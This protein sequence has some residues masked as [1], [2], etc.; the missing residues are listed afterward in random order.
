[1]TRLSKSDLALAANKALKDQQRRQWLLDFNGIVWHYERGY[2]AMLEI[3][4]TTPSD[5][6]PEGFKYCFTFHEPGIN[7]KAGKRIY[8][9]DNAHSPDNGPVY[10]HEH[11][12]TWTSEL[13][14]N[15]P[16]ES[17]PSRYEDASIFTAFEKFPKEV[18]RIMERLE[19]SCAPINQSR[20]PEKITGDNAGGENQDRGVISK[21]SKKGEKK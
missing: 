15:R 19:L 21:R 20:V 6:C 12:T 14:G 8:G 3:T 1:M 5:H 10:D 9:L 16:K 2:V 13:S 7:G 11:K 4:E 18:N 17:K